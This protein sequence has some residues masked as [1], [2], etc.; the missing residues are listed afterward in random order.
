MIAFKSETIYLANLDRL[1][2]E[3]Y[4]FVQ[5]S[6]VQRVKRDVIEKKGKEETKEGRKEKKEKPEK[7]MNIYI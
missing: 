7:E 5:R 3:F 6:V 1:D 4:R 2:R